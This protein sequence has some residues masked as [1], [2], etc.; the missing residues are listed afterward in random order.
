M[1]IKNHLTK[2][3][4]VVNDEEETTLIS[5][6]SVSTIMNHNFV[7]IFIYQLHL[8]IHVDNYVLIENDYN[9]DNNDSDES[10]KL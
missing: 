7:Q 5:Y 1:I 3:N 2:H 4:K 6:T 9:N 8:F 10:Y